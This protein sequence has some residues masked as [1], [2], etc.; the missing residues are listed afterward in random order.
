MRDAIIEGPLNDNEIALLGLL[1]EAPRYGYEIDKVIKER[2]MREWT[3]IAFSS[4][5][6]VLRTLERKDLVEAKTELAGNRARKLYS[7]TRAGRRALKDET[8]RLIATPIKVSDRLML[9]LANIGVLDRSTATELLAERRSALERE[10]N[11]IEANQ[12][13]SDND[14]YYVTALFDRALT[15]IRAEIEFIDRLR[16]QM[17]V[18]SVRTNTTPPPLETAETSTAS[19]L[20]PVPVPP[21]PAKEPKDT[22]F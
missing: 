14:A 9:G 12:A 19:E 15:S 7:L 5:Y 4:I 18:G 8:A 21:P 10:L 17:G 3:D 11:L 20:S 13:D 1:A 2:G 6:A 16:T 22:L